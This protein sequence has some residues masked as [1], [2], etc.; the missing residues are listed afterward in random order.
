[1][2]IILLL[3]FGVL[4]YKS[5]KGNNKLKKFSISI[6]LVFGISIVTV[7]N[8]ILFFNIICNLHDNLGY[9][10]YISLIADKIYNHYQIIEL[11]FF[12]L[13]LVII[14]FLLNKCKLKIPI[15]ETRK[16]LLFM[17]FIYSIIPPFYISFPIL[18]K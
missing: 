14:P 6:C 12:N 11:S 15:I 17:F 16:V 4:S 10:H 5:I 18:K 8:S 7:L 9:D 2:Y 1:M 3:C 13:T